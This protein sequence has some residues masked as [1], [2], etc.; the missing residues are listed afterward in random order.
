[1]KNG[2]R[3]AQRDFISIAQRTLASD[4]FAVDER[5]VEAA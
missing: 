1:M 3:R 4:A 5:A 2:A